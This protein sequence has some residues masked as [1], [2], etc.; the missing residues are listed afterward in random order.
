MQTTDL[1]AWTTLSTSGLRALQLPAEIEKV[2]V[3]ADGNAP[4]EA[5]RLMRSEDGNAK[6]ERCTSHTH[7][8]VWTSTTSYAV[9]AAARRR[10]EHG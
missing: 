10:V 9:T 7:P 5:Q 1:P 4:G 6:A 8:R 2:I 3:L